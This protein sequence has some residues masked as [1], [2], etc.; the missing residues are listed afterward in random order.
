MAIESKREVGQHAS[1]FLDTYRNGRNDQANITCLALPYLAHMSLA[2]CIITWQENRCS[3]M[4]DLQ[5]KQWQLTTRERLVS[6]TAA[7]PIDSK[8]STQTLIECGPK[9]DPQALTADT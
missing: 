8:S 5:R 6:S 7:E 3:P 9:A 1:R 4:A 2:G